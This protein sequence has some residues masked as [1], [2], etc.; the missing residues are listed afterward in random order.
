M[1]RLA[2]NGIVD[3][4]SLDER[5]QNIH[6]HLRVGAGGERGFLRAA[7]FAAET[8]F[9]ALVICRVLTTLRIRRRISRMLGIKLLSAYQSVS[10]SVKPD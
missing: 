3:I 4:G 1:K 9:I 5:L 7:E 8:V 2:G 6:Q 10:C